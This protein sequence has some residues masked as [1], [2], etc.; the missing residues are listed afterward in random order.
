MAEIVAEND[1]R[2]GFRFRMSAAGVPFGARLDFREEHLVTVTEE[3]PL[4]SVRYLART[5]QPD[6]AIL[7][8][9]ADGELPDPL[10]LS[11]AKLTSGQEVAII[12]YPAYDSRNDPEA[13]ARY[14]GDIFDVKR[15]APGEI[16]QPAERRSTS[17]CTTR[18]PWAATRARWCSTW[19]P[20]R[21]SASTSREAISSA[22]TR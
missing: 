2:G 1:G 17:S 8:I 13:M 14:F 18:R 16:T 9:E 4:R 19:P 15:L 21:P 6:I 5:D 12:G 22:T 20:V 11:D 3:V 7:E 10:L